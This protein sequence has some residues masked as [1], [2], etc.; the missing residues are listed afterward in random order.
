MVAKEWLKNSFSEGFNAA[1]VWS[2]T[3]VQTQT[4]VDVAEVQSKVQ[5]QFRTECNVWFEVQPVI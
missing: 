4:S 5:A 3:L 2:C 1:L